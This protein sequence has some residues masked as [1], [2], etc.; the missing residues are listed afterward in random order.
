MMKVCT[1]VHIIKVIYK[2]KCTPVCK[3]PP[4]YVRWVF[5]MGGVWFTRIN[6]L[7]VINL[8][9]CVLGL[10]DR[11]KDP[12]SGNALLVEKLQKQIKELVS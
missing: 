1:Y 7:I 9:S 2:Y 10:F 4:F 12:S 3:T 11:F 5:E 8:I 6:N